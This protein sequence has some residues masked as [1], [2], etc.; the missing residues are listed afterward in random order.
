MKYYVQFEEVNVVTIEIEASN[1]DE[2]EK[3]AK[4]KL[5]EGLDYDDPSV[6]VDY[7]HTTDNVK[8]FAF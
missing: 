2:A 7:S 5:E 6:S 4:E 3:L 1:G 8:V